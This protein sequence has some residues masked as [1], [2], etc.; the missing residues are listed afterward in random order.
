MKIPNK[1]EAMMLLET[2]CEIYQ[3]R[4][5]YSILRLFTK[6]CTVWGTAVDEFRVGVSELAKQHERDWSQSEKG[7]IEIINFISNP[8]QD[9]WAGATCRAKIV[10]H[11][12]E[13]IFNNLRATIIICKESGNWKISHM[14]CS[15]PD[16]R[17][18]EGNSFPNQK[19]TYID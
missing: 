19:T 4:D 10:I 12:I 11:D 18:E 3:A 16:F 7:E 1:N 5:L 17:S 15:F 2:Y 14:H 9:L 8:D 6:N 13:H